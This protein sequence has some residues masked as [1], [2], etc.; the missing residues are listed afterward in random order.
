MV[1]S[2]NAVLL[3]Y[4]LNSFGDVCFLPDNSCIIKQL[5]DLSTVFE[6]CSCTRNTKK[7]KSFVHNCNIV[8][9]TNSKPL[10]I[11]VDQKTQMYSL[12]TQIQIEM[13]QSYCTGPLE[14]INIKVVDE[15][16]NIFYFDKIAKKKMLERLI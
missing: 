10:M 3:C 16:E 6:T 12:K 8:I 7:K 1:L 11:H 14:Y 9:A 15:K 4:T 13:C 2:Q 5:S